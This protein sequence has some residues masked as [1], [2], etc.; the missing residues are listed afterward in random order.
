MPVFSSH[1]DWD[2]TRLPA[3]LAQMLVTEDLARSFLDGSRGRVE[4]VRGLTLRVDTGEIYGLLGPN[5]AGKTT[6]LRLFATLLRPERGR[7]EI[8]GIDAVD[9]PVGA[10]SRLAYVPAEAG[11]PERLTPI[12]TVQLFG[13]IQGIHDAGRRAA[14]LLERLGA[15]NYARTPCSS[16]STGMKRRVVLARALIHDPPLLLLDE[17]TDGLDVG[18]RRDVLELVRGL[19]GEGR[20]VIV[21][22]HIMGEVEALC[23]RIGVMS[24]G[25]IVAEGSVASLLSS[26]GTRELGDAFLHLTRDNAAPARDNAAPP[27]DTASPTRENAA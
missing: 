14:D 2:G 9:D 3:T 13:E 4:A 8:D 7:I 1:T 23:S 22:S 21:S 11:L 10:R 12:E 24:G 5:G 17:P 19:A 6:T 15:A 25:R 27:R 26:T 18:G 20:A 16:L